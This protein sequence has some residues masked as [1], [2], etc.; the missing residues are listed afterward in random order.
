[1]PRTLALSLLLSA[2]A[3]PLAAQSL[4]GTVAGTIKDEQGGVLPGVTV[5]LTGKT[6]SRNT[7]T[8][9]EGAYRFAAL[10][11]GTYSVTATLTGFRPKRQDNV[12]VST[13]RVAEINM[14]LSVGGV[15]ENVDV[16]GESAVVDP[17]SSATDNALS[18]QMLF[19][20]PIRPPNAATDMLNYLPGIDDGS[21]YGTNADYAN[22]LLID[23]VDTR[24]PEAGSSW[25]FFN[26]N[27]MEEVDVKGIGADAEYG[28]YTGAVINTITK[29]GGNR[30]AGLFDAYWT[31]SSFS[32]ENVS[33][34]DIELNPS[35]AESAI[36]DKRLDLTGQLSGPIIEDKLFFF[37]AGQRFEQ[38]DN[39]SGP[40]TLHH[41]VSPRF[42][43][44]LT[45][46]PGP[47]D[48]LSFNLQWDYYNQT[49]RCTVSDALC[50]DTPT[51][52]MT[53]NQDSPEAVWGLQWRHL[54]GTHTFAEVKYAGWWGYF[55][56]DPALNEPG[57]Y[58]GST[59]AYSGGGYYH[60]YADRGRNQVNASISHY[61]E[62]FGKHDLKFGLEIERSKVHSRYGF[63]QGIY[64][65]DYS[66]YYPAGQYV[67][68]TYGYDADARNHRES[69]FA[70]DAW[71]ATGRLTINAGVRVDFVRGR[72]PALDKTV[73]SNTDWAPRIGFAY[74]LTG[75]GKTVLK[76]HYG[77]Y[78]EAIVSDQYARGV[79]GWQDY[80][81]YVYDP[82]GS[83]C[84]PKGNCFTE[85]SRLLYPVYGIDPNMKHPRVDE[86][87]AGFERELAKGVRLEVTGIW[88]QDRNIQA[89]VYP[90]ARWEPTTVTNGLTNLPLTVY[91]W[92]NVDASQTT[93]ILT[94]VDGF[95]YREPGG[96]PLG[97][98][99]AERKYEA[100]MLVL[101]KRFW[102]R[103]QGRISYVLSKVD[104]SINN[105]GANTYGQATL[106]ET[107][108]NALVN[109]YGHPDF[110]RTHEV[111][112]YGTWQIPKIEVGLNAYYRFMS[113][114]TWTP[115]ERYSSKLIDWPGFAAGGRQPFLEPRGDRRLPN[116]SYLDLRVEKIF[117]LGAGTDR[118]SVYADIQNV[119]NAGT[120]LDVNRRYPD[121]LIAGY[122]TPVDFGSPTE[123]ADPRKFI[124]GARWSF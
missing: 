36:V 112:A 23:G 14:T 31:R 44:K 60:Y 47:N 22:G 34:A 116:E 99:R 122:D 29:S 101:D 124:L 9:A 55:Y 56:L 6:G 10:D 25:V 85:S 97:T 40:L 123:I 81:T 72:S 83:L 86:W 13:S 76:G 48:N 59:G 109:S 87:T 110:D 91:N 65:Y 16:V 114:T 28:S 95:V 7:T 37:V 74:D 115:Y 18:P 24:D 42:N 64:Y 43:A 84:G 98:A 69:V 92:A 66:A 19:N 17:T 15:T 32:G 106:F 80:V 103:W 3:L 27:L 68:Y 90:D 45:W 94:N 38:K 113:G 20:L 30:Y 63:P 49:G 102:N 82:G 89:S 52:N 100:L 75:D 118:L 121:V 4:T 41:E 73:Y 77:Q 5:T 108:T 78:Y 120:V 62:R 96:N 71:R 39:P 51:A 105:T 70:Q 46:Q 79:P 33:A 53:V 119:F 54:F 88:R 57:H 21:A 117:K 107:P 50:T 104:S 8:D 2:L 111:K 12:V 11:P 58:D 93:P 26:Y 67:A 61:A 1:M 35:L